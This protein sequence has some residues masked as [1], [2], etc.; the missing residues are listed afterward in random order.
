MESSAG[1]FSHIAE[2]VLRNIESYYAANNSVSDEL[3]L[4]LHSVFG[5]ISERA[6][7]LLDSGSVTLLKT[8][9]NNAKI[10]QV[11]GSSGTIYLIYPNI[12]FCLCT[13]YTH[14]V[15]KGCAY[16]CK[17]VLAALLGNIMGSCRELEMTPDNFVATLIE[18]NVREAFTMNKD[19]FQE[20]MTS[21]N[22][23]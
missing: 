10:F 14:Q 13:F 2:N 22:Q 4:T 23:T 1:V 3:L 19:H 11:S 17:H 18:R 5:D 12:N 7:A 6:L 21:G 8:S 9:V 20:N 15:N 16:T